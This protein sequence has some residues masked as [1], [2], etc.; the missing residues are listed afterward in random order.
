VALDISELATTATD[1]IKVIDYKGGDQGDE[2]GSGFP[3]LVCKFNYHQLT[4]A[5][6]AA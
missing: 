6:G 3:I 2:K 1:P 5:A 4:T